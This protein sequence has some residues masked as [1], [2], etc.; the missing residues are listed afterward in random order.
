MKN[1]VITGGTRGIGEATAKLLAKNGYRV[2]ITGRG[3]QALHFDKKDYPQINFKRYEAAELKDVVHLTH[4]VNKHWQGQLDG[5]VNNAGMFSSTLLEQQSVNSL[6]QMFRVN[7]VA[8]AMLTKAFLPMLKKAKGNIINITSIAAEKAWLGS[9][10]YAASKAAINQLTRVWAVELAPNVR[11]NAIAPGPID[12]EIL[13]NSGLSASE[14]RKL[15]KKEK[16]LTPLN[17]I[18]EPSEIANGVEFFLSNKAA[19]ITGQI[20]QID[21][22]MGL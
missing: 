4:W 21:G 12:T 11:V 6:E 18:A 14:A 16:E 17:Q 8:T 2:L 7:V 13:T 20:L 10:A 22:G 9:G 15:R 1:V 5:L 19:H 3:T